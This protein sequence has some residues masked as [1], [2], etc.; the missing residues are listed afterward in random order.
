M[1]K[2][3]QKIINLQSKINENIKIDYKI[4]KQ[5]A[6]TYKENYILAKNDDLKLHFSI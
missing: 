3:Q 4:D 6:D 5:K 1:E 2:Y